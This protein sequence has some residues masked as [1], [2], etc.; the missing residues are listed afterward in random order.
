MLYTLKEILMKDSLFKVNKF[1]F[2]LQLNRRQYI[3]TYTFTIAN[4]P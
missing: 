4:R 2:E 1:H 3:Y